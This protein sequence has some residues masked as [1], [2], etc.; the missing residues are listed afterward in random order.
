MK[1]VSK[2]LSLILAAITAA[3]SLSACSNSPSSSTASEPSASESSAASASSAESGGEEAPAGVTYPLE[4]NPTFTYAIGEE[5][6]VTVNATDLGAT[7]FGQA[8]QEATGV[9]LEIQHPSGSD[10]FSL[11]FASGDLP[12]IISYSFSGY[13]GGPAK[14]IKD[15]IIY[16]I[17]DLIEENAPDLKAVLDGNDLYRK[18][19]TSS[20]GHIVGFPFI[21][22]DEYLLTS[23]GMIVRDDWLDELGL[24]KPQT[25]DEL[26]DLLITFRDEKGTTIPLAADTGTLLDQWVNMGII[27][28]PYGLVRGGYYQIDGVIHYGRAE[29]EYKDVLAFLNKLYTDGLLDP[30]FSTCDTN[31]KNANIMNG[32]SGVTGGSVG[33]GIGNFMQ[34]ME[35]EDFSVTGFGPLVAKEGDRAMSTVYDNPVVGVMSVITPSCENKEAAAQFLNYGYTEEGHMLFNFGIEGESYTMVDGV[36]TYTELITHNPDGWTMQQALAQYTRSWS[37]DAFVQD[38]QYMYQYGGLPQQKEALESW[39]NADASKYA[40]PPTTIAEADS[41]EYSKLWSDLI[42]YMDEMFVKFVTG[43]EPLD[44]FET[45]YLPMLEQL[46]IDRVLELQ[47]NA[48]DEFNAR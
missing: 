36:P 1:T 37:A 23:A 12:D 32:L 28:S 8:W 4:G 41:A 40:V 2:K 38:V 10:G 31:T 34:T 3:G 20:D 9:T 26:Y 35:G 44:K 33:S 42:T 7:P 14:A 15:G 19:T 22:G 16:P 39:T 21:R 46:G 6:A 5:A 45:D 29:Q 48:L 11:L 27:T 17:E 47:Q 24:D 18:S 25:P 30:N 43:V 13:S